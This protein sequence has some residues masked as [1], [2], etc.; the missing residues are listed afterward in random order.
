MQ[1]T[2]LA[3]YAALLY[4]PLFLIAVSQRLRC[5]D[6]GAALRRIAVFV[7]PALLICGGVALIQWEMLY[8]YYFVTGYAYGSQ[9]EVARYLLST[10]TKG[11]EYAPA[12]LAALLLVALI[13][14]VRGGRPQLAEILT[15][16]WMVVG[17]PVF[18]VLTSSYYHGVSSVW[19]LLIL[20]LLA[21][22]LPR[23]L[24][25]ARSAGAALLMIAIALG[26]AVYNYRHAVAR[27][28]ELVPGAHTE[29]HLQLH[30]QL[31]EVV[32]AQPAPRHYAFLFSE[33]A[34]PF[35]NHAIFQRD[36]R[37]E[38]PFIFQS[39]HDSYYVT[40]FGEMSPQDIADRQIAKLESVPGAIVV[41]YCDADAILAPSVYTATGTEIAGQVATSITRHLLRSPRWQA[42]RSLDS[43]YGCLLVY[44]RAPAPLNPPDKWG[45]LARRP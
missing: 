1:R 31:F 28:L 6:R 18:V 7:V 36:T 16:G 15:A 27:S 37:L 17:F 29:A 10:L 40:V 22:A 30:R 13:F 11:L 20:V 23:D 3:I 42:I 35:L 14:G 45:N 5:D 44:R 4:T 26:G 2:A 9:A 43:I 34:V 12:V 32:S 33:I 41:T 39:I 8:R 24:S 19:M 21:T 38:P 25:R